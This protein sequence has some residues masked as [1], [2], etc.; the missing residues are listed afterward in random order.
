MKK[1]L[2]SNRKSLQRSQDLK[3][4]GFMKLGFPIMEELTKKV[5]KSG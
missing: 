5:R 1:G 2:V 4:S 3:E